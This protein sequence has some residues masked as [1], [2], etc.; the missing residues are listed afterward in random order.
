MGVASWIF[1]HGWGRGNRYAD[2]SDERLIA[3]WSAQAKRLQTELAVYATELLLCLGTP[4]MSVKR[5]QHTD[6][7]IRAIMWSIIKFQGCITADED[8][9]HTLHIIDDVLRGFDY[10]FIPSTSSLSSVSP[11]FTRALQSACSEN[12]TI[13]YRV[14]NATGLSAWNGVDSPAQPIIG[15]DLGSAVLRSL[16][17]DSRCKVAL[18]EEPGDEQRWEPQGVQ[19][20]IRWLAAS[21]RSEPSLTQSLDEYAVISLFVSEPVGRTEYY[22]YTWNIAYLFLSRW[23]AALPVASS[24]DMEGYL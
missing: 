19:D 9:T 6:E 17:E 16:S 8:I 22:E 11:I 1:E 4:A 7:E 21:M 23:G 10:R 20:L 5:R 12:A 14:L 13:T 18:D 2:R 24:S 3:E 15:A